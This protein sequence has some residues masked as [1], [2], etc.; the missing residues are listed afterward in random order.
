MVL[1]RLALCWSVSTFTRSYEI[2]MTAEIVHIILGQTSVLLAEV[3]ES[4]PCRH[5]SVHFL[6]R[7]GVVVSCDLARAAVMTGLPPEVFMHTALAPVTPN[8]SCGRT[9]V[10]GFTMS[11]ARGSVQNHCWCDEMRAA[12]M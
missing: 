3:P 4:Q 11:W 10:T 6:L 9:G 1:A 12:T 7:L 2:H 5:I 8:L